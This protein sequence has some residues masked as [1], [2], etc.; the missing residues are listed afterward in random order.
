MQ[1]EP[2]LAAV[3]HHKGFVSKDKLDMSLDAIQRSAGYPEKKT[4]TLVKCKEDVSFRPPPPH[5]WKH[6][7]YTLAIHCVP[8]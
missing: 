2:L 5:I 3:C 6:G 1:E 8:I 7:L 4:E